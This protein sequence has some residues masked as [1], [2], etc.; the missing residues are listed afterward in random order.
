[1]TRGDESL[2]GQ[3]SSFVFLSWDISATVFHTPVH[4]APPWSSPHALWIHSPSPVKASLFPKDI[5]PPTTPPRHS[6]FFSPQMISLLS[7]TP[8]S[9]SLPQSLQLF[10]CVY[11]KLPIPF[12]IKLIWRKPWLNFFLSVMSTW[13]QRIMAGEKHIIMLTWSYFKFIIHKS[14]MASW[15]LRKSYVFLG[16]ALCPTELTFTASL[17]SGPINSLHC[18]QNHCIDPFAFICTHGPCLP[19]SAMGG[20]LLFKGRP[21]LLPGLR[22]LSPAHSLCSP[23]SP[24]CLPYHQ[25]ASLVVTCGILNA[26]SCWMRWCENKSENWYIFSKTEASNMA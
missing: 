24:P 12:L 14:W 7:T 22:P 13:E 1:M 9:F 23:K 16:N 18:P 8:F 17:S 15:A 10:S 2:L 6:C 20:L 5:A 4:P 26:F 11:S 19:S 3:H 25:F 21:R